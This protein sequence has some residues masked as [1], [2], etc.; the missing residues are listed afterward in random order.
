MNNQYLVVSDQM[1]GDKF[2]VKGP[3][4]FFPGPYETIEGPF[5]APKYANPSTS[6]FLFLILLA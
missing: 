4:L 3:K 6:N 2:V 1:K 5:I